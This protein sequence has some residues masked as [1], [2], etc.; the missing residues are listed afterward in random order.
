MKHVLLKHLLNPICQYWQQY[1]PTRLPTC[2]RT[3]R[4]VKKEQTKK[5]REKKSR[6][7]KILNKIY[8]K[9]LL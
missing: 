9:T 2:Y 5:K 1:C 4:N 6:D 8:N 7:M 3:R